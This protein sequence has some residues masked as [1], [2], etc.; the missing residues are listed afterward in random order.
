MS[1]DTNAGQ[2]KPSRGTRSL[3]ALV[4]I[5]IGIAVIFAMLNFVTHCAGR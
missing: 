4:G 1:N 2:G 5:L 3:G